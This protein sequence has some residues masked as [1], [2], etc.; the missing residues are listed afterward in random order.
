M[1][2]PNTGSRPKVALERFAKISHIASHC[3]RGPR[4]AMFP[5]DPKGL[6]LWLEPL[7]RMKA[8]F[9]SPRKVQSY[10]VYAVPNVIEHDSSS[11]VLVRRTNWESGTDKELCRQGERDW[12]SVSTTYKALTVELATIIDDQ[13]RK[14]DGALSAFRFP[15]EGLDLNG[16]SGIRP[17]PENAIIVTDAVSYELSR[18]MRF[19]YIELHWRAI[20]GHV[21][22]FDECWQALLDTLVNLTEGSTSL[23]EVNVIETYDIDPQTYGQLLK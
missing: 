1:A 23:M 17:L 18:V 12:P 9:A 11:P 16:S 22:P 20:Q 7:I 19:H 4:S 10:S 15:V 5:E 8:S 14:L 2:D 21:S 13:V 6:D 3:L